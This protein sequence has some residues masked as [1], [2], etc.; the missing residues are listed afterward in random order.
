MLNLKNNRHGIKNVYRTIKAHEPWNEER[1]WTLKQIY[2]TPKTSPR[3]FV[4]R[5]LQLPQLS[6]FNSDID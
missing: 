3:P 2:Q 1:H 6:M 4:S 5:F